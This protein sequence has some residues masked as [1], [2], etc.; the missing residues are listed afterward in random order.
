MPENSEPASYTPS[1]CAHDQISNIKM[2]PSVSSESQVFFFFS[3]L[4]EWRWKWIL[5]I[6]SNWDFEYWRPA[7]LA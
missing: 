7:L 5:A 6:V 2:D 1:L 3:F 4:W